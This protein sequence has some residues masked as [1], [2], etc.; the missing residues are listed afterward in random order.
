MI[1]LAVSTQGHTSALGLLD[2]MGQKRF[3]IADGREQRTVVLEDLLHDM[4]AP[5]HQKMISIDRAHRL[6]GGDKVVI[7]KGCLLLH[8]QDLRPSA[9]QC[10]RIGIAAI[11]I[12]GGKEGENLLVTPD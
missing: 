4:L 6:Q 1:G 12:D 5:V 2:F 3:D 7:S 11:A 10:C 9:V 8:E